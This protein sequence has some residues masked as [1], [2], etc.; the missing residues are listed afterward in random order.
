MSAEL[1]LPADPLPFDAMAPIE[2]WRVFISKGLYLRS[3]CEPCIWTPGPNRAMCLAE[4][5]ALVNP[6]RVLPE[7]PLDKLC[8]PNCGCG[9]WAFAMEELDHSG[10]D[11]FPTN[12]LGKVRLWGRVM[13]F[14]RGFRAEYAELVELWDMTRVDLSQTAQLYE[15]PLVPAPAQIMA[16]LARD[17]EKEA[18]ASTATATATVLRMQDLSP[19]IQSPF[20]ALCVASATRRQRF[21][22]WLKRRTGAGVRPPS[23]S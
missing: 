22:R 1:E 9:F 20:M 12:I 7:H 17:A 4:G 10:I 11:V 14:S 16:A 23:T 8:A 6:D 18:Y 3:I 21:V 13:P 19:L 5:N 15:V 2:G